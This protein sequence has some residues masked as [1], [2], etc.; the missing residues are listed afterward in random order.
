MAKIFGK[1]LSRGEVMKRVGDISQIAD[2]RES[3][4]TSGKG[5]SVRAID[6]KTGSGLEFTVL[7]SRGMDIAWTGYQGKPVSFISKAGI[8]R[9]DVYEKDGLSFLRSFT[10]G[11]VTT[12]GLTYM[13]APCEDEGEAL[14]LHGRISNIPAQDV[15]VF[16]EWTGDDFLIRVRGKVSESAMFGEN[17]VLTRVIETKLGAKSFCVHDLVENIGFNDQPFMILYHINFGYPV[18]SENSRLIQS[19]RPIVTARDEEAEKGLDSYDQ[20]E[21]PVHGYSEQ[22]FFHDTHCSDKEEAYGCIFN[23]ELQYGAYLKYSLK[24][25]THFGVW[26]MMGEGDYVVGLE[27]GNWYP[28]GRAE[29]RKRGELKIL[30]PGEKAEFHYEIGVVESEEEIQKIM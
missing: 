25:F 26:K 4:L 28:L 17:M 12:C 27:P 11:M 8:V 19:E 30:A 5:E 29:A 20:F 15:S 21:K 7:P 24:D 1:E 6:V 22:V 14:G 3:I 16:K 9:P 13:G 10:C 18:V 23:D 2:A